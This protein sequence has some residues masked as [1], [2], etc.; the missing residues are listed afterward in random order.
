M[1]SFTTSTTITTTA[2]YN[3]NNKND[4]DDELTTTAIYISRKHAR[5][6]VVTK[7]IKKKKTLRFL[8]MHSTVEDYKSEPL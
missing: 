1:F 2:A 7:G 5:G 8:Q 3:N 4:D 6:G